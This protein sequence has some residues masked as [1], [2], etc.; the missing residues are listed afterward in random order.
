MQVCIA[1]MYVADGE[2]HAHYES[3]A[4]GLSTWLNEL[5]DAN[6]RTLGIDPETV[7]WE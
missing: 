4:P 5:I 3:L 2:F 6:A 1:Q 7:Q